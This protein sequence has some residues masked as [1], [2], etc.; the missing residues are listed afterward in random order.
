MTEY[1]KQFIA[2][3]GGGSAIVLSLAWI[4]K[5]LVSYY[6]SKNIETFRSNLKTQ[7]D[8]EIER[9][10]STLQIEGFRDQIRFTRLHEKQ[11]NTIAL[12]YEEILTII[13][14]LKLCASWTKQDFDFSK[15]AGEEIRSALDLYID[16]QQTF[17]KHEIYF[18]TKLCNLLNEFFF[19]LQDT[20]HQT[21]FFGEDWKA[22]EA[23]FLTSW[24]KIEEKLPEVLDALRSQFRKILGVPL[25][26]TQDI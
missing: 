15:L 23:D 14:H 2:I 18:D 26:T 4:V 17:R 21:S 25:K 11:A 8:I 9:L 16:A 19:L 7:T 3:I 1:I 12:L 5:I 20:T 22:H 6:L 24:N 10:R 13:Q